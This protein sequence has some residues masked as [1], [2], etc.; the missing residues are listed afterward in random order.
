V[1]P[2][3]QSAAVVHGKR[4][5]G[6]HNFSVVIVQLGSGVGAGSHFVFGGHDGAG[7]VVQVVLEF[8]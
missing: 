1:K 6:T 5:F 4:Y 7:A 8:V 2:A 3:P